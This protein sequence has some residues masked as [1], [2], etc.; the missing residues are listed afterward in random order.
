[1]TASFWDKRASKYDEAVGKHD[2]EFEQTIA[3]TRLLLADA[4]V[5]LD[6]GCGSGEYSL[7]L[8]GHIDRI[9]GIDTSGQMIELANQKA[10]QRQG[11]N[12]SFAAVDEFDAS[13]AGI[14]ITKVVAFNV[15]HLVA[16]PAAS[17]ARLHELL[18]PGGLLISATPCLDEWALLPR[19]L[20]KLMQKVGIAPRIVPYTVARLESEL[21]AAGFRIDESRV[22]APK[23]AT[24]WIVATAI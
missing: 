2:D 8:A 1:M 19:L 6:F 21:Q 3:W 16:E 11:A 13:I 15:L 4:D 20:V 7:E 17:L 10:V 24:Q 14:G 22:L 12:A 18:K 23:H 5:V 9:H